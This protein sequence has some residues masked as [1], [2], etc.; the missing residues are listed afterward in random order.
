MHLR[1]FFVKLYTDNQRYSKATGNKHGFESAAN[2]AEVKAKEE[3]EE[4]LAQQLGDIA[5]AATADKEHIQQMSNATDDMLA[6]IK[7]QSE[8]I[9]EL[10]RQNG[11]LV[12]ALATGNAQVPQVSTDTAA[13]LAAGA[14]AKKKI[15]GGDIALRDKKGRCVVC[16]R[17]FKTAICYELECNKEL[18]PGGWRSAFV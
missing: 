3:E 2:M 11:L 9:K 13:S 5:L 7:E 16:N 10:V 8:Q 14:A 15:D 6:I 12:A 17:H 1:A 4:L 18:H